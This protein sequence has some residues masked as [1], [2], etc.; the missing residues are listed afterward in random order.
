MIW[1][2]RH[3]VSLTYTGNANGEVRLSEE[4]TEYVWYSL[5]EIKRLDNLDS[6]FKELLE[7]QKFA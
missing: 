1:T 6:Y 3:V 2:D 4:H 7:N 5:E